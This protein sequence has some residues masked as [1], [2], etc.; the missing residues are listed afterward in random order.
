MI[1]L[2]CQNHTQEEYLGFLPIDAQNEFNDENCADIMWDFQYKCP[3]ATKFTYVL[4]L[5]TIYQN[6]Q[7]QYNFDCLR[8]IYK[9]PLDMED[10]Y[11]K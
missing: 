11:Q 3:I 1:G 7:K 9:I 2:M 8:I 4:F 6:T 5:V 10:V